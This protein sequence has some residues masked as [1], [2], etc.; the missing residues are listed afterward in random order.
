MNL[1]TETQQ[2]ELLAN[3]SAALEARRL[4]V[5]FDPKPVVKFFTPHGYCRW[6]LTELNPHG[7]DWAYGLYDLGFGFPQ[8]G[9]VTL[10]ELATL[11]GKPALPVVRDRYFVADRPLS[12]YAHDA[13]SRG[14]I[15]SS[16][17]ERR[18]FLGRSGS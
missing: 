7:G 14:L 5:D 2:I 16:W 8:L 1:I 12:A 6:L 10:R 18:G 15:W 3:G 13:Q 4:G 11:Q 17:S 9:F